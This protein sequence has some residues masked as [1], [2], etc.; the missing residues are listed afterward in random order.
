MLNVFEINYFFKNVAQFS[1]PQVF[2]R[3]AKNEI[4]ILETPLLP[5]EFVRG[6]I[7]NHLNVKHVETSKH[8]YAS[9]T[10]FF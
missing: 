6:T 10:F 4:K 5:C 8:I 2:L 3:S 1:Y 7:F 9:K